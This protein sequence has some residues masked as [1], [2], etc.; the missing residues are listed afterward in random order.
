MCTRYNGL[1]DICISAYEAF[2]DGHVELQVSFKLPYVNLG[3]SKETDFWDSF[4]G[5]G[6]M[7]PLLA[8]VKEV[9]VRNT[10]LLNEAIHEKH[11]GKE[12]NWKWVI[13]PD[14]DTRYFSMQDCTP[15]L[16]MVSTLAALR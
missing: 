6:G 7:Q 1:Q 9:I 14:N 5:T 11:G 10:P 8:R 2:G 16:L 15:D 12:V 13:A 4:G 3:F